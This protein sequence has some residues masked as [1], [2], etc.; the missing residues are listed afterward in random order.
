MLDGKW[1]TVADISQAT[2][3]PEN[4]VQAQLRHLRK[5]RFGAY[6]V[7]RQ[8]EGGGLYYYYLRARTDFDPPYEEGDEWAALDEED[9]LLLQRNGVTK[10]VSPKKLVVLMRELECL[11]LEIEAYGD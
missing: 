9:R 2:G 8:R 3:D 11:R 1:R 6:I 7:S 4:S 10:N 5:P